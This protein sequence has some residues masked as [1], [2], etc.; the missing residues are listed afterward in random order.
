MEENDGV[1]ILSKNPPESYVRARLISL[2]E[3]GVVDIIQPDPEKKET[4]YIKN[5]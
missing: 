1:K 2:K 4:F 3:Q 5:I